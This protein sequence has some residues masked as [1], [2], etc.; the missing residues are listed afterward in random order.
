MKKVWVVLICMMCVIVI[1][2][3]NIHWQIKTGAPGANRVFNS[4][5]LFEGEAESETDPLIE[6]K[7]EYSKNLPENLTSKIKSAQEGGKPI[8]FVMYG[9][10]TTSAEIGAWPVLLQ[11]KL[12]EAY[13]EHVFEISIL[14]EKDKTSKE[15]LNEQLYKKVKDKEPDLLLIEPFILKDNGK[16]GILKTLLNVKEIIFDIKNENPEMT[17]M[18]QPPHPL[19]DATYY[20]K[21]VAEFKKFAED[22]KFI[23]LDHWSNWPS[24]EDEKL[25]NYLSETDSKPNEKG[26]AIWADFLIRYFVS[27]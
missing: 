25:K 1:M 16:I 8:K 11:D 6:E 12:N 3:G 26:H 18:L 22:Q 14:S 13:G 7:S 17:I 27:E 9:S 15:V 5:H 10:E 24:S 2:A 23:F 4:V 21:E 20:P 19:F